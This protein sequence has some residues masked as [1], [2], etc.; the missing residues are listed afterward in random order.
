MGTVIIGLFVSFAIT[1]I[2]CGIWQINLAVN[3][4]EK[5]ERLKKWKKDYAEEQAKMAEGVVNG[6]KKAA[7][8]VQKLGSKY[9]KK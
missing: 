3:H 2:A 5:Y 6:G 9:L 7:A 4:P 8:L 1:A